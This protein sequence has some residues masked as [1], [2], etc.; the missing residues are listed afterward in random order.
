MA[1]EWVTNWVNRIV[2]VVFCLCCTFQLKAQTDSLELTIIDEELST[3]SIEINEEKSIQLM[4]KLSLEEFLSDVELCSFILKESQ[5][6]S[7]LE[8]IKNTGDVL[9]LLELQS[10]ADIDYSVYLSLVKI[11]KIHQS[12]KLKTDAF[13]RI[14]QRSIHQNNVDEDALGSKWGMYQQAQIQFKQGTKIGLAR[15]FDVGENT[16][17]SIINKYD[18]YAWYI[19][20][21]TRNMEMNL[22][23]FQVYHGL[24]LIIGQGFSG[25]FGQGGINN[26]VQNRWKPTANQIEYNTFSGAYISK[27]FKNI[28]LSLGISHQPVDSTNTFGIHRTESQVKA[29]NKATEK[30]VISTVEY[31]ARKFR[32]SM[33]YLKNK[34]ANTHSFSTCNQLFL[35]ST[36]LFSELAFQSTNI[37]YSIGLSRLF[38][39][40]LQLSISYTSFH[41][42]FDSE[43]G[44]NTVQG[45]TKSNKNGFVLHITYLSP[46]KWNINITHKSALKDFTNNKTLGTSSEVS[47]NLRIYRSFRNKLKWSLLFYTKLKE[48]EGDES[49][50]VAK[51]VREYRAGSG[52]SYSLNE[53]VQQDLFYYRSHVNTIRSD[54]LAYQLIIKTRLL[55]CSYALSLHEINQGVPLYISSA[56]II[57]G[58]I[59]QAIYEKGSMQQWGI[60]L[61]VNVFTIQLQFLKLSKIVS[62][63]QQNKLLL[64]IKYP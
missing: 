50:D 20:H 4:N 34:S 37:T 11:I 16:S 35:G 39:K 6:N 51:Q 7:I 30:I 38:N 29:K 1:W 55:K 40:Y 22:G 60:S 19:N 45:I 5:R 59:T 31:S 57:Q 42:S 44:A 3:E 54:A 58:R 18:H 48:Q 32:S 41:K 53:R 17:K 10:L 21:K 52:I 24:G 25:A 15:E 63:E 62:E 33:L 47:E 2:I 9:D 13:V 27:R 43:Y 14:I 56:S 8:H 23:N 46:S 61:K 12:S 49:L 26:I 36:T 28:S 64:Q